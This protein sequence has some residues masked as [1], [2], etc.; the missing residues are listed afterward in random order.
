MG[1]YTDFILSFDHT[2]MWMFD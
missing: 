1:F 2:L